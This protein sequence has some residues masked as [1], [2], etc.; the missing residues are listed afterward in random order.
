MTQYTPSLMRSSTSFSVDV[1]IMLR[2]YLYDKQDIHQEVWQ[3]RAS[4]ALILESIPILL[5]DKIRQD[6]IKIASDF[7]SHNG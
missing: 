1:Q 5:K 3:M 6:A 7:P 2:A 4:L